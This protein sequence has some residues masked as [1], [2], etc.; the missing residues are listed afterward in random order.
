MKDA[1]LSLGTSSDAAPVEVHPRRG[2]TRG[3]AEPDVKGAEG[4][5]RSERT[6]A[7]LGAPE[8]SSSVA[9]SREGVGEPYA[10]YP[11]EECECCPCGLPIWNCNHECY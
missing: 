10:P 1:T 4:G 5:E 9:V 6:L 11:T 3:R 7:H 8:V 2:A